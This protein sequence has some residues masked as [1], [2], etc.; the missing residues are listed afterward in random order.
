MSQEH[1]SSARI[2]LDLTAHLRCKDRSGRQGEAELLAFQKKQIETERVAA[3]IDDYQL[4][5]RGASR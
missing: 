3:V 1:R 4:Q 5:P 2:P